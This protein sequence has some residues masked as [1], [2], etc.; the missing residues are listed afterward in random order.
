[1]SLIDYHKNTTRELL[2]LANNVRDLINHHGEDGRYKEAVLK[3]MI[4]RFL[5]EKYVLATGFVI[6][7]ENDYGTHESSTQVD[8]VIYDN[9]SPVIFK[10]GDFVILTPDSVRAIIEVKTNLL[11]LDV[12]AVVKKANKIGQFIFEGKKDKKDLLFNGIFSFEGGS[13]FEETFKQNILFANQE[14]ANEKGYK[15]F[16]VNH[17]SVNKDRFLKFWPEDALPHS[18]YEPEDLSFPFFISNLIAFLASHSV[19]TNNF[20]WFPNNKELGRVVRF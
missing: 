14:F 6:R 4:K 13:F 5:P 19:S 9:S 18:L 16:V 8:L 7:P 1:M 15:K 11:S 12:T 10:E 2:S 20:I 17:I 3:S